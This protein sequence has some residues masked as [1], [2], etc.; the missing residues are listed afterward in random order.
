MLTAQR[1]KKWGCPLYLFNVETQQSCAPQAL[2]RDP[3][4]GDVAVAQ[5]LVNHSVCVGQLLT[6]FIADDMGGFQS[7]LYLSLNFF[8]RQMK[9]L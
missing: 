5:S 2:S 3:D 7:S 6:V 8:C 1:C 4:R 9:R